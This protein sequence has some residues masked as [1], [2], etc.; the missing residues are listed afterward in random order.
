MIINLDFLSQGG[1]ITPEEV[2]TIVDEKIATKVDYSEYENKVQEIDQNISYKQDEL[3]SGTN[4]KTING[5][6]ILGSGNIEIQ[7]GGDTVKAGNGIYISEDEE[8][9]KVISTSWMPPVASDKYVAYRNVDG[10]V[11]VDY[12][13]DGIIPYQKYRSNKTIQEVIIGNGI[14]KIGGYAFFGCENLKRINSDVDGVFNIPSS[15]K[16]IDGFSF[17]YCSNVTSVTI[18]SGVTVLPYWGFVSC[19]KLTSVTIPNTITEILD[20][21]FRSVPTQGT[22]YCDEDWF[23]NLSSSNKSHLGNVKNWTRKPLPKPIEERV[24]NL[25]EDVTELSAKVDDL[26]LYKFP[27]ATI[28]GTP[29]INNGQVSNFSNDN[30]LQFPFLVDF[31]NREFEIKFSFTTAPSGG[32]LQENILDSNYGLAFAIREGKFVAVASENGTSWTTGEMISEQL[33]AASTTYYFTIYWKDGIFGYKGGTSKED[34]SIAASVEMANTPFPKT[35]VI[36]RSIDNG[37]HFGGSINLNDASLEISNKVVWQGMDDVGLATRA[38]VDLSN[39][40]DKG[41]EVI[42]DLIDSKIGDI[43]NALETIIG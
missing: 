15:V 17:Q 36:G 14:T 2:E 10:S 21:V 13:E 28:F 18:P 11:G 30:Y 41:K 26:Q 3:I 42:N 22:L 33:F 39:I 12:F 38:A 24:D 37:N 25:E 16:I 19:S 27:N 32:W 43:N 7:G 40:D 8:G 29:T 35:M 34:E 31:Q 20:D 9:A 4:I 6:S 23:N 1:G 5:N